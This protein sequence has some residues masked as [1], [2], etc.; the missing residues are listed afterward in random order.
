MVMDPC[1]LGGCKNVW[2]KEENL[3]VEGGTHSMGTE[4]VAAA[5]A[6]AFVDAAAA[7]AAMAPDHPLVLER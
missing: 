6:A 2:R 7:Y 3:V 1:N 4:V 5:E